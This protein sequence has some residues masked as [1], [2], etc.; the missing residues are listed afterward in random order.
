MVRWVMDDNWAVYIS[1]ING[2]PASFFLNLEAMP[3]GDPD[4]RPYVCRLDLNL[5]APSEDG[6]TTQEE[7]ES[8]LELEDELIEALSSSLNGVFVGRVTHDGK[9]RFSS[10]LRMRMASKRRSNIACRRSMVV[11]GRT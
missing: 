4:P 6:L 2:L 9:R 1:E 10:I 11:A 8:L 3:D 7:S 5:A